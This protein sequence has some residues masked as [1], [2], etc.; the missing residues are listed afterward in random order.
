MWQLADKTNRI[1]QDDLLSIRELV[2]PGGRIK[3]C[4]QLILL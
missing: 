1:R 3:G 2:V 4:K